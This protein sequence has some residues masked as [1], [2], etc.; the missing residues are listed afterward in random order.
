MSAL[1]SLSLSCAA[2]DDFLLPADA[3]AL[4]EEPPC[5]LED[6]SCADDV[7]G[8]DSVTSASSSSA[9]SLPKSRFLA[10]CSS[11]L[12]LA[13]IRSAMF[14][15]TA[16]LSSPISCVRIRPFWILAST[17]LWPD[18]VVSD[19]KVSISLSRSQR[20]S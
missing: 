1:S 8:L 15:T 6:F 2:D 11:S 13:S 20:N 17:C 14:W 10:S 12:A 9:S 3:V 4:P 18:S 19:S 5:F 16:N 7:A